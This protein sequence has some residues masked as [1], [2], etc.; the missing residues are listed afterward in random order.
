MSTQK[1]LNVCDVGAAAGD[2]S[3]PDSVQSLKHFV[4]NVANKL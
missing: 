4:R 2:S 3:Y 1:L